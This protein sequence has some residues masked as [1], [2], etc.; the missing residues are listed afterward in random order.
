MP[1][2]NLETPKKLLQNID[3]HF[4]NYYLYMHQHGAK[5]E[6]KK[7]SDLLKY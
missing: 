4:S 7:K 2:L 6:G 3:T 1:E 5:V